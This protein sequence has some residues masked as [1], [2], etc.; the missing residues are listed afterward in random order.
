MTDEL[1][2]ILTEAHEMVLVLA[3]EDT[4]YSGHCS[5]A[6]MKEA[7]ELAERIEKALKVTCP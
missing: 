3:D 5:S 7:A 1:R 6:L 4:A 2:D